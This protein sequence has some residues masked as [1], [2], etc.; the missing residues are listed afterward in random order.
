MIVT[1][2][3]S[4]IDTAEIN[5]QVNSLP[6]VNAG[7]NQNICT[8]DTT[9][10]NVLGAVNYQWSP[11]IN[12]SATNLSTISAWPVDTTSYI[13]TGIDANSCINKDT[14]DINVW[15]LPV[16]DAGEDLWI[17]PGGSLTL[18]ASGGITY[19]W[20]PDSTLSSPLELQQLVHL[21]M[22]RM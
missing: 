3:N 16:A 20:F 10:I 15:N 17:C 11:N 8:G 9:Q 6:L 1:G 19:N 18:S 13:V 2:A 22:K 14:I 21:M 12:I 5:I 4:C 7:I